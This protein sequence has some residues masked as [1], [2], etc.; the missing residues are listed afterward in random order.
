MTVTMTPHRHDCPTCTCGRRAPV[1]AAYG[2]DKRAPGTISWEEHLEAYEGFAREYPFS[3]SRQTAAWLAE[4]GGF[5]WNEL[6]RFLG[7]E[8]TTWKAARRA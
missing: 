1:Q 2:Q 6:V 8:P 5:G 4:R 3:A 7:R